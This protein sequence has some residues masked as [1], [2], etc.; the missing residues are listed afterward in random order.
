[1]TS[2][3]SDSD[4]AAV[5][6]GSETPVNVSSGQS[7]GKLPNDLNTEDSNGGAT[8]PSSSTIVPLPKRIGRYSIHE[9]LGLGGMGIVYRGIDETLMRT[10]AVKT[11]KNVKIE[12]DKKEQFLAEARRL[13][14]LSHPNV[15]Q[16]YDVGKVSQRPYFVMEFLEDSRSHQ[17]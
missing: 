15:V 6:M 3:F 10:V 4:V 14:K 1:M 8:I 5:S 9:V 11:L 12:A 2:E 16:I 7:A 17:G 13:A